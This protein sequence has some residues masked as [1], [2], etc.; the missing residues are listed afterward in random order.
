MKNLFIAFIA[1][2]MCTGI[3]AQEKSADKE[4]IKKVITESTKAY[5][6]KDFDKIAATFIHDETL[7][8][9]AV[10]KGGFNVNHGWDKVGENYKNNFKNNPEPAVGKFE[11]TNF[12]IK[13]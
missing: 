9:T 6:A 8:K 5:R 4:A 1:L 11:K 12:K 13:V 2:V 3:S 7:V 10:A